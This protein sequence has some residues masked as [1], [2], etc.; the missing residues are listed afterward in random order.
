MLL[1]DSGGGANQLVSIPGVELPQGQ[2][3]V[4]I[5]F[6]S[7][8][9]DYFATVGTHLIEGRD[10]T[11]ADG[12]SGA[13]VALISR[14]MARRF[15]PGK[16]A[17]GQHMVADGKDVHII[18]VVEDATINRIHEAP[19]P[20]MY[21]PFAQSPIDWGTLIVE[22]RGDPGMMVATIRSEIGNV[23]PKVP[24]EVRTLRSLMQQ[25]FWEDQTAAVFV[26]ALGIMGMFLAAIG[27]Y[28]VIAFL[29]DRRRHEIGIRMALGAD[30]QN[31]LRL[32]LSQGLR[33]AVIGVVVGLAVSFAVTRLMA[34]LLYGVRP[35]DPV[36]FAAS[37]AG[38]FLIA[39]VASY[40]PA[41]RA[42]RVDPIVALRHE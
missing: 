32:V 14:T 22:T 5:K 25:A 33:L 19:E 21:L 39:L 10:F 23:D 2:Q 3:N 34:D 13:R 15:W 28:G 12:P 7:V 35:R 24:V 27:L 4:P 36:T 1:S 37:S 42:T 38:V 17:L 16:N 41:W 20:Y 40:I 9:L 8:G 18:G 6:N 11:A 29:A 30:H 31:V 26:G